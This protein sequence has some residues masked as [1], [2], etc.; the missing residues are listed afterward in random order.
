MCPSLA[1]NL[2]CSCISLLNTS[3]RVECHCAFLELSSY[4]TRPPFSLAWLCSKP[5][6]TVIE[7]QDAHPTLFRSDVPTSDL[8]SMSDSLSRKLLYVLV[9]KCNDCCGQGTVVS[10]S[11]IS[12]RSFLGST[13]RLFHFKVREIGSEGGKTCP[14]EQQSQDY[15]SLQTIYFYLTVLALSL[16]S[17]WGWRKSLFPEAGTEQHRLSV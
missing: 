11:G 5:F 7:F 2:C 4:R 10:P 8:C 12:Q 3:T 9:P 15:N 17:L 6:G 14:S 16:I 13:M 1:S